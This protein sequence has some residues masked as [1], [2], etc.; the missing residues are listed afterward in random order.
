MLCMVLTTSLSTVVCSAA[1]KS[2]RVQRPL[3]ARLLLLLLPLSKELEI[4]NPKLA[5]FNR[6]I[7]QT[8]TSEEVLEKGEKK[9]F[10]TGLTVKHPLDESWELPI[11]VANFILMDYGTGAIF[12]CPAHDQRDLEF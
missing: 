2:T 3:V 9:G 1:R 6:S 5:E 11:W 8:G 10:D 7:R 12:A 4:V